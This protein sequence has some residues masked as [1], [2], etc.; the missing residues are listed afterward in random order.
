MFFNKT[1]YNSQG[2]SSAKS[3]LAS[4]S[5]VAPL[6]ANHHWGALQIH[7]LHQASHGQYI[8][9]AHFF[10]PPH[11][12]G[13]H[14]CYHGLYQWY[15]GCTGL[16]NIHG[17]RGFP[18]G[19]SLVVRH[20]AISQ[21]T[22]GTPL[23]WHPYSLHPGVLALGSLWMRWSQKHPPGPTILLLRGVRLFYTTWNYICGVAEVLQVCRVHFLQWPPF[24]RNEPL[25]TSGIPVLCFLYC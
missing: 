17:D 6:V 4:S 14:C 10:I 3:S 23:G 21:H 19:I 8:N 20:Q 15:Q 13:D 2:W 12:G 16:R 9:S 25:P 1:Y 18:F 5:T 11:G 7:D 22:G 24:E